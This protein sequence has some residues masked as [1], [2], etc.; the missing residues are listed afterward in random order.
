MIDPAWI[1]LEP[2][3]RWYLYLFGFTAIIAWETFWPRR[4]LR[5][6]TAKRWSGQL[7]LMVAAS[8]LT[9]WVIPVS[10]I[11]V[12]FQTRSAGWGLLPNLGLPWAVQAII[13][14]LVLDFVRFSQ[15]WCFH[16][17]GWLW[18]IHR[19]HHSD[20][21]FD[22]TTG[23]RFHPLDPILS[24]ATYI[25]VVW[26]LGVPPFAAMAYELRHVVH[27]FFSHANIEVPQRL[28]NWLRC[29][30]V[31]PETHRVHHSD[32]PAENRE[33]YGEM[34]TFW[35][36]VLGTYQA[37]PA[38]GHRA[39]GIGIRGYEGG[40]TYNPLR[41]LAWPLYERALI[42]SEPGDAPAVRPP[43]GA[44]STE[45][46]AD[47]EVTHAPAVLRTTG[48]SSVLNGGAGVRLVRPQPR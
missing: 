17:F 39:M 46:F 22:L 28:E 31:T 10:A 21:D 12:A 11:E 44:L 32:L 41:L 24:M 20:P 38:N 37:Q 15:H 47:E 16:A 30:I 26:A 13:G 36:R 18:R 25:P 19:V 27:A 1:E 23:I 48:R 40:Q 29:V 2:E 34:F 42:A 45:R 14:I 7:A 5:C 33:N 3:A 6:S 9:L 43:S 35:D 8:A 4:E